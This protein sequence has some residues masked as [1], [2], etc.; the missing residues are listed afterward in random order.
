MKCREQT[1]KRHHKKLGGKERRRETDERKQPS[2]KAKTRK[3]DEPYLAL[4]FTVTTVLNE[5]RPVF[6]VPKNVGSRQLEAK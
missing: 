3:Y 4:G 6:T 5:E 2:L 1:L